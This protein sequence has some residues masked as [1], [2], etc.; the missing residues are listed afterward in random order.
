MATT[1]TGAGRGGK[2]DGSGRPKGSRNK[3]STLL[4]ERAKTKGLEMPLPRL[5]RRMN[6]RKL[7]EN[8]RD[9]LAI[10]AAAYCH[11]KLSVVAAPR[12][13]SAMT[14]DELDRA[15]AIAEE[16][17]LRNGVGRDKWPKVVH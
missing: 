12:R 17:L 5:L 11:A 13:P 3:R 6:D 9:Q 16:D 15:I 14:D 1:A 2:R 7:P 8:Y 4:I 10:A